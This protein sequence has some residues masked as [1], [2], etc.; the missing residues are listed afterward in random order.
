M[1]N[2]EYFAFFSTTAI[3]LLAPRAPP[4]LTTKRYKE[5]YVLVHCFIWLLILCVGN[6]INFAKDRIAAALIDYA[7]SQSCRLLLAVMMRKENEE[8]VTNSN[9]ASSTLGRA[10][11]LNFAPSGAFASFNKWHSEKCVNDRYSGM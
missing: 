3:L 5:C 6:K 1:T 10:G 7:E 4:G 9:Y 8:S 2:Q 11:Q